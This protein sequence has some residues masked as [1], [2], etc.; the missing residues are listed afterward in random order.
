MSIKII[1]NMII[2]DTNGIRELKIYIKI[3]IC[4]QFLINLNKNV[5]HLI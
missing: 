5:F 4:F 1:M 2:K 3:I